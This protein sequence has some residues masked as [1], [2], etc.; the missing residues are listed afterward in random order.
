LIEIE[1]VAEI[2]LEQYDCLS[3]TYRPF[4]STSFGSKNK[5]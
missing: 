5:R 4:H 2:M 1:P 3:L